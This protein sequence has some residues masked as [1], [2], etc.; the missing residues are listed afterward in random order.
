LIV[1]TNPAAFRAKYSVPTNILI[2]GPYAGQLQ[3]SG[4]N[5]ELQAPDNPNTNGV[6]YVVIDAVRYNDKAPWPP[7]ADGSGMSLQRV[8]V[9]GF[10]NE[11]LNW[12]A[13]APTPGE[14]LGAGDSDNDGMPDSWEQENGTF[15][16]VPDAGDDPD[17]D[18]LTNLQEYLA[19]THP[20]DPASLLRI[21]KI[22]RNADAVTLQFRAASNHT[23]SVLFQTTL[24]G[25]PWLRLADI[26]AYPTNRMVNVTNATSGS[27][28]F[29]RLV[30]PAQP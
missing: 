13:A 9:S 5:L 22:T 4:E 14:A 2:L 17:G 8:A 6:P 11:P 19:G 24:D 16:F 25:F 23:Y 18:G 3:D 10:G 7:A 27:S 15:V 26:P 29:Y 12:T 1:A 20:H 28:R 21:E 30:T